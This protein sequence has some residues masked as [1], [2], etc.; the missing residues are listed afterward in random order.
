MFANDNLLGC[1]LTPSHFPGQ[2]VWI[3]KGKHY[4][5]VVSTNFDRS[6]LRI[7]L[8]DNSIADLVR[9]EII[10]SEK[11]DVFCHKI[12]LNTFNTSVENFQ[13]QLNFDM[14]SSVRWSKGR[15]IKEIDLLAADAS[16]GVNPE[17]VSK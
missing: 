10:S 13:Y 4:Y 5:A 16:F 2:S 11:S 12:E 3:K 8:W 15:C 6:M 17:G 7:N 1:L 9:E 14:N